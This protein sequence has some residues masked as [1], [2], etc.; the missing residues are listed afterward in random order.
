MKRTI[1]LTFIIITLL[2]PTC[3][4]ISTCLLLLN[5]QLYMITEH[6]NINTQVDLIYSFALLGYVAEKVTHRL[7]FKLLRKLDFLI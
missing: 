6:A 2:I 7:K 4:Y 3:T 5:F 1:N